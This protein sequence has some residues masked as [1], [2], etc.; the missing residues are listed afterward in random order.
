MSRNVGTSERR[1][2][3]GRAQALSVAIRKT[4]GKYIESR[5]P[6]EACVRARPGGVP[7]FR[8][9]DTSDVLVMPRSRRRSRGD[10]YTTTAWLRAADAI[11]R[12]DHQ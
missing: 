7:T 4:A 9:S 11:A 12:E 10:D 6:R 2:P 8:R 1:N 5:L 3:G